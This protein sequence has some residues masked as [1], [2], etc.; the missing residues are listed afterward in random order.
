MYGIARQMKRQQSRCLLLRPVL[1]DTQTYHGPGLELPTDSCSTSSHHHESNSAAK[2]K[3]HK[4]EVNPDSHQTQT[5]DACLITGL[6]PKAPCT[7]VV[8][9]S[10]PCSTSLH[11]DPFKA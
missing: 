3:L 2:T 5:P 10:R 6:N 8:Y 4:R 11:R 1:I 7:H 9:T